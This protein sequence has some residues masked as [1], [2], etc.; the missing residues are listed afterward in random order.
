MEITKFVE[1]KNRNINPR[2]SSDVYGM[3]VLL[4]ILC[5]FSSSYKGQ[6]TSSLWS[7]ALQLKLNN[8]DF[9]TTSRGVPFPGINLLHTQTLEFAL[10]YTLC[11]PLTKLKY[12]HICT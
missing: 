6:F 5:P 7:F 3:L 10:N 4:L 12:L 11:R 1:V 9:Y 2:K 8:S